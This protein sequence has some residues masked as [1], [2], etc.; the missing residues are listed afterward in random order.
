[1]QY[2]VQKVAED[3][4]GMWGGLIAGAVMGAVNA[5]T[6][7]ADTRTW[8]SLPKEVQY[9]RLTTPENRELTLFAGA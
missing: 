4:G 1:M 7:I 2:G 6:N 5:S 9:A 8:T 3:R